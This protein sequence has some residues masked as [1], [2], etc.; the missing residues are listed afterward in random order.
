[1]DT[2]VGG[3][4]AIVAEL[5]KHFERRVVIGLSRTDAFYERLGSELF[6][7]CD[8]KTGIE[9]FPAIDAANIKPPPHWGNEIPALWA[10]GESHRQVIARALSDGVKTLLIM[11]DDCAFVPDAALQLEQFM[12]EVPQGWDA[13]ML[14]GQ[15]SVF[16]GKTQ[17]ITQRVSKCLGHVER[18][19]CYAL[20]RNGMQVFH[21][22]LCEATAEPNDYRWGRLQEEG[23]LTVYRIEPFIAYQ[24]DGRSAISGRVEPQRS[25]DDRVDVRI[26]NSDDIPVV[27]L[28]CPFD[29]LLRLRDEG[30]VSNGGENPIE[31]KVR[32]RVEQGEREIAGALA[33]RYDVDPAGAQQ[34]VDMLRRDA[35]FHR[36]AVFAVWHPER[37]LPVTGAT[38]VKVQT[39]EDAVRLL[40]TVRLCGEL[41]PVE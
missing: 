18:L 19:H 36:D 24:T 27:A 26:R 17:P 14:G 4:A 23:K 8:R 15:V 38:P 10:C 31:P 39:Y 11:E 29:V 33:Y 13:L 16:D 25:W 5:R 6:P 3:L 12:A 30:I 28:C 9:L 1:M 35:A 7:W 41:A 21:D 20:S 34:I 2:I 32:D 40:G 37:L 22:S